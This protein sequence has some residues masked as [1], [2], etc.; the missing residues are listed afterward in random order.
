MRNF[1]AMVIGLLLAT[2]YLIPLT[3]SQ[4]AVA[5]DA[6]TTNWAGTWVAQGTLFTVGVTVTSDGLFHVHKVES[7]GFVWS[8]QPG[9][10]SGD[11][12]SVEV[13]YAG[14]TALLQI[15]LSG[16]GMAVVEAT[17]CRPDFMVVCVLS[18]GQQAVFVRNSIP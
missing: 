9:R 12:A 13:S 16:K 18:R 2:S 11:R 6:A 15:R 8:A 17:N 1:K 10:Y 7:L 4:R 14:A 5:Q 3:W